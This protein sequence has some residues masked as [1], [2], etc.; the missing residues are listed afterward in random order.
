MRVTQFWKECKITSS[1]GRDMYCAWEVTS[2]ERILTWGRKKKV[3]EETP[4]RSGEK[5]VERVGKLSNVTTPE[6]AVNRQ[7]W[8]KAT[9]NQ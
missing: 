7:I 3:K 9:K 1:H 5:E 6:E 4:K 2:T 8:R